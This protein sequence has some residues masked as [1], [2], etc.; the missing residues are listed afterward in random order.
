[1]T[2]RRRHHGGYASPLVVLS[3]CYVAA[4]E[5][6]VITVVMFLASISGLY[7]SQK[8]CIVVDIFLTVACAVL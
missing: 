5:E 2:C 7:S 1:L 6:A 3:N 4:A 8:W